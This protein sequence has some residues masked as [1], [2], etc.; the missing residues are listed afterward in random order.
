MSGHSDST[1]CPECGGYMSTYSDHKP[2][3]ITE[4]TCMDCGF[5]YWTETGHMDICEMNERRVEEHE[6]NPLSVHDMRK[7]LEG[8]NPS[9]PES[10]RLD[11]M[12]MEMLIAAEAERYKDYYA[13]EAKK[14]VSDG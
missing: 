9:L 7:I 6:K 12:R 8:R 14:E 13:N 1:E 11:P 3:D 5:M 10:K 4:G 2:H